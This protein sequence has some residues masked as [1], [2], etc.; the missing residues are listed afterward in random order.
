MSLIIDARRGRFRSVPHLSCQSLRVAK[1]N[2]RKRQSH[3]PPFLESGWRKSTSLDRLTMHNAVVER[4]VWSYV[5]RRSMDPARRRDE[6]HRR[7][8]IALPDSDSGETRS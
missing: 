2:P 7:G 4:C 8:A 6:K 1:V 5:F 3:G